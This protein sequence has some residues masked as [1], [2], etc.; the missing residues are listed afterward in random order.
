MSAIPKPGDVA[1]HLKTGGIYR[2]LCV[3]KIE[4]TLEPVVVYQ[5]QKDGEVWIRPLGEFIDGRFTLYPA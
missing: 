2:V 5:S 3:G 4:A 1:K